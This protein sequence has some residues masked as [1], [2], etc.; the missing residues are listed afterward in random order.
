[1]SAFSH[2]L[3]H[4][5]GRPSGLPGRI[6]GWMMAKM[7]RLH[8]EWVIGLLA[9]DRNFSVVEI[10]FGPGAGIELLAQSS[11][12]TYIAGV[13]PSQE[14]FDQATARN[15]RAITRGQVDLRIGQAEHLPFGSNMF[16][17]A[18]AINSMQLWSDR[19]AGLAEIRRVLK[20]GGTIALCFTI[21]SGQ[22]PGGLVATIAAA[23]FVRTRL[24][25]SDK[26]FCVLAGRRWMPTV[27]RNAWVRH[28]S[29]DPEVWKP[30][31]V[32]LLKPQTR[33][34]CLCAGNGAG[35]SRGNSREMS[36]RKKRGRSRV[37]VDIRC[38]RIL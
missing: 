6:G 24:V 15:A 1:M 37:S 14:M 12:A 36:R 30:Y 20:P 25:E 35:N 10:G 17:S 38:L 3:M 8:A 22:Q 19:D 32:E 31:L 28:T 26:A 16:D 23:G 5:F 4:M 27:R 34:T 7:N 9:I 21:H 11:R 33:L 29:Q 18:F 13:D 2:I